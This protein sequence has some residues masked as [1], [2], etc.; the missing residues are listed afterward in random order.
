M[1]MLS[2]K[3]KLTARSEEAATPHIRGGVSSEHSHA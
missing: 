2:G 1:G 3:R